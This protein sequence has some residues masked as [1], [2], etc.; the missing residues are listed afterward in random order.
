M[1]N[2]CVYAHTNYMPVMNLLFLILK[3]KVLP[4]CFW[5]HKQR[6]KLDGDNKN[7][8]RIPV[9]FQPNQEHPQAKMNSLGGFFLMVSETYTDIWK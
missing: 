6:R 2:V 8:M 5:V 9:E 1:L 7:K 3:F 4:I